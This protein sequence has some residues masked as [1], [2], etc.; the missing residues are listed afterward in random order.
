[1]RGL[2][3]TRQENV[4]NIFTPK[5]DEEPAVE[6]VR[7]SH[8]DPRFFLPFAKSMLTTRGT[9]RADETSRTLVVRDDATSAAR[10]AQWV[11]NFDLPASR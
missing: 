8:E 2:D 5:Q 4:L 11:K 7:F 6:S 1:M 9:V 3:W 10:F